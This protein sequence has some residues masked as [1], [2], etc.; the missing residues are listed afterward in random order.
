LAVGVLL[1]IVYLLTCR[2]LGLT[3]LVFRGDR[4]KDADL[5][6]LRHEN[7]VLRRHAGPV[8]YEPAGRAWLAALARLIPRRRW[9]AIF[10]ITPATLLAWHRKLAAK[11]YDTA[12]RPKPPAPF[13][14]VKSASTRPRGHARDA[15]ATTVQPGEDAH[16]HNCRCRIRNIRRFAGPMAGLTQVDS[17]SIKG[18]H[19]QCDPRLRDS[20]QIRRDLPERHRI[21]NGKPLSQTKR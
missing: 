20:K 19:R 1:N 10:P 3:V 16:R 8:R 13:T 5:L 9:T 11:K 14:Q 15:S 12:K 2:V 18:P 6:V 21:K 4:T 7:A 17:R